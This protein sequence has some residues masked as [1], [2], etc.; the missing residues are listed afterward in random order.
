MVKVTVVDEVEEKGS[1]HSSPYSSPTSSA[2][3]SSVSLVSEPENDGDETFFDRVAALVDIVPPTTRQKISSRVSTTASVVKTVGQRLGQLAWI[4]TTS[5]LLVGLPLALS[6]EDEARIVAQ[7]KEIAA[8]QQGAQ[9][10]GAIPSWSLFAVLM[11]HANT[12]PFPDDGTRLDV[13]SARRSGSAWPA[14]ECCQASRLVEVSKRRTTLPAC[15][16]LCY[17]LQFLLGCHASMP[18]SR[19]YI[20]YSS[21]FSPLSL[22]SRIIKTYSPRCSSCYC[23][24]ICASFSPPPSAEPYC[25]FGLLHTRLRNLS[26][27]CYFIH[28]A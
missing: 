7:E 8:Q 4:I 3:S 10:V 5:A 17:L 21:N 14:P 6:L 13:P 23:I 25:W 19:Q 22:Y 15:L 18:R 16:L 2:A 28:L 20:P 26:S 9:Q 24:I 27:C 1:A 11:S 12:H